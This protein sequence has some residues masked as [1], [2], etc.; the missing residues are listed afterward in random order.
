MITIIEGLTGAGKTYFQTKLLL[1]EWQQKQKIFANYKLYF[2]E[3]NEDIFRWHE[4][5]EIYHLTH[6]VLGMDEIQDLAGHW[7]AIPASF[8][9]KLSHH[10]HQELDIYATTQ[11]FQDL[12]IEFRRNTHEIFRAINVLRFPKRETKKPIIQ[13]VRVIKKKRM[14]TNDQDN[15]KFGIVRFGLFGRGKIFFI[16]KYWTKKTYDTFANIDFDKYIC[17]FICEK[18]TKTQKREWIFKIY[19]RDMVSTGRAKL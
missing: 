6:G 3:K 1:K 13:I 9:Q 14:I 2:S 7:L 4:L 17:K 15:I 10:R 16:S 11:A 19:N 5:N 8:R 12:H 18:K